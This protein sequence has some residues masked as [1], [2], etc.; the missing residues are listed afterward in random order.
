MCL[1]VC[2]FEPP[3]KHRFVMLANRDEFY[4]RPA[5][6]MDWWQEA[7][8]ILAGKDLKGGGTWLGVSKD[9]RFGALTNYRENSSENKKISR[10]RLLKDY[11]DNKNLD[12]LSFFSTINEK[13]FAG[14]SM[15]LGDHNGL[16]Y[17]SNRSSGLESLTS[18]TYVLANRSL[19]CTKSK[20]GKVLKSFHE[21]KSNISE[22]E[23]YFRFM[24]QDVIEI[25]GS[26]FDSY[27]DEAIEIPQRFI[28]SNIYG[29]RCTSLLT[30]REDGL[31]EIAEK[32]FL[33][34]GKYE[35]E[36][37]YSFYPE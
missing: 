2:S 33:E 11:L 31:Y 9:G 20:A 36:S 25:D 6:P 17:F 32:R 35:G 12:A 21:S 27:R 18:G 4:S 5:L 26:R 10:G 3:S 13:D 1:I 15:L 7:P 30:I 16:H 37:T 19:N 23:D 8:D 28:S 24:Q 34:N 29:T 14:F 22:T